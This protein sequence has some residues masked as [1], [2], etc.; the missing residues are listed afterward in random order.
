[1]VNSINS[2][3]SG[4]QA[5]GWGKVDLDPTAE[6]KTIIRKIRSMCEGLDNKKIMSASVNGDKIKLTG[7]FEKDL[8]ELS[9]AVID[10]L[11]EMDDLGLTDMGATVKMNVR[12]TADGKPVS[13]D[14]QFNQYRDRDL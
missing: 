6:Q 9:S 2:G 5:A 14:F 4:A 3:P 12:G 11:K 8:L 10:K 7:D 1:M 13:Q